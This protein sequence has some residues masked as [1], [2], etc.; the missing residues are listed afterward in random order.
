VE[1]VLKLQHAKK[2]ASSQQ[3]ALPTLLQ[4][5]A[6]THAQSQSPI[7]QQYYPVLKSQINQNHH[8]HAA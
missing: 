6:K 7:I 5:P 1:L 2:N 4:K 8:A 3:Q